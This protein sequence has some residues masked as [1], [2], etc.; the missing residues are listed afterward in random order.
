MG[1]W[2]ELYQTLLRV[3]EEQPVDD[4][5]IGR[6][7]DYAAWCFEQP[8]TGSAETDPS[9]AVAVSLVENIPLDKTIS[10]D[11][12]RWISVD[13]FNGFEPLFRYHL[14]DAQYQRFAASFHEKKKHFDGPSRL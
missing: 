7:Y 10:E 12:Y 4:E 6:I 1:L 9:S 3:Y 11:L 2:I 14:A 13:S 8:G 5:R